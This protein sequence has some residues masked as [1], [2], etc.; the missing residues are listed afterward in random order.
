ME[1]RKFGE[2]K[3]KKKSHDFPRILEELPLPRAGQNF[4][5]FRS[6]CIEEVRS[7]GVECRI[8]PQLVQEHDYY[9]RR[10]KKI[11]SCYLLPDFYDRV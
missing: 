4:W 1:K 10:L 7:W 8:P 5:D 9:S 2:K 6:Q 11:I 3:H